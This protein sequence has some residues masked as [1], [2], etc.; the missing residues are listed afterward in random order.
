MKKLDDL[1]WGPDPRFAAKR[2]YDEADMIQFLV[3]LS[4]TT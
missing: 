4:K 1:F 3:T 2:V